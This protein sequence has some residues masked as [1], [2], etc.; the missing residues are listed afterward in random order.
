MKRGGNNVFDDRDESLLEDEKTR[1]EVADEGGLSGSASDPEEIEGKDIDELAHDVGLY[2]DSSESN[3]V[4]L[5]LG[6]QINKAEGVIGDI[7]DAT[8]NEDKDNEA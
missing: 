8:E 3:P 4:E 7:D 1:P 2:M 5:G 6:D